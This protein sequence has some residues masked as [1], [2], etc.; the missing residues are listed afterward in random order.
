[1]SAPEEQAEGRRRLTD[2][3]EQ[4]AH[5]IHAYAMRHVGPDRAEEVVAETFLVAWRRLED[6]PGSGL[7]WLL[8]VARNTIRSDRRSMYR[9]RALTAEL[10]RLTK[11]TDHVASAETLVT[12]RDAL[13]RGLAQLS[14]NQ[15][16]AILLV[17][18]DGLTTTDAAAVAGCALGTFKVRLHRARRR[19]SR[20]LD[21]TAD[22]DAPNASVAALFPATPEREL[23]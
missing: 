21:P 13:L 10:E 20:A 1:M 4:Y 6:V 23:S 15:R 11:L 14:K 9:Q 16:E 8:V 18:W 5:R 7:P 19:M 12:E 17:A 22:P 2:L 3:W